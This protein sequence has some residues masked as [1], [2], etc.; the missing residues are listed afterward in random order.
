MGGYGLLYEIQMGRLEY[1]CNECK[2]CEYVGT[3]LDIKIPQKA[4]DCYACCGHWE[5][6][7]KGDRRRN[8][9]RSKNGQPKQTRTERKYLMRLGLLV[10]L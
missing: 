1:P 5:K 8:E 3:C 10:L 7:S 9:N 2:D 6:L 4:D